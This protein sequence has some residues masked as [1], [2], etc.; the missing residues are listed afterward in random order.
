MVEDSMDLRVHIAEKSLPNPVA[1]A[2]GVCG[3]GEEYRSLV[4]LH[5]LGALYTKAVTP[6]A[7]TGNPSP[8]LAE[9]SA[10][11]LNSIG[12]ANPG[13]EGFLSQKVPILRALP[14][15]VIVNVA[16]ALESDYIA[17]SE[18]MNDCDAVWGVELNVSCPNVSHGGMAFGTDADRLESLLLSVRRVLSKPLIVKLSPNVTDIAEM[19]RVAESSGVDALSCINT[20]TGMKVDIHRRKPAIARITGGLSGPAIKPVGVATV[21]KVSRAVKVP[22]I[23]LG[24]IASAEDAIEYLLAGASAVQVGTSLFSEPETPSFILSGIKQYMKQNGFQQ[25]SDFHGYF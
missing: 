18:V 17:V 3:F 9:T 5:L 11:L 22:V 25:L 1:L 20:L 15:P 14:C 13:I 10:G 24:G 2:S 4:D 6:E 19:A 12:L 23:G 8:R 21:W 7:R 16:G